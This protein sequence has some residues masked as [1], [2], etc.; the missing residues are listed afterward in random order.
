MT[1][2]LICKMLLQNFHTKDLY[3]LDG[4][5]LAAPFRRFDLLINYINNEEWWHEA[6][7]EVEKQL[8]KA[9]LV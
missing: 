8:L 5:T 4:R 6:C 7:K 9:N 2:T 1:E 3:S